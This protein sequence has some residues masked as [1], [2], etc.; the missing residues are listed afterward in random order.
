MAEGNAAGEHQ[1]EPPGLCVCVCVCVCVCA[2]GDL[3][4]CVCRC[5]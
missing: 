4:Y 5:V 3:M 2:G 1:A